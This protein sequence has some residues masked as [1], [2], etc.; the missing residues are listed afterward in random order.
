M[1]RCG[2]AHRLASSALPRAISDGEMVIAVATLT[3][4][5]VVLCSWPSLFLIA[6]R[7]HSRRWLTGLAV[8]VPCEPS[9]RIDSRTLW[10]TLHIGGWCGA[11]GPGNELRA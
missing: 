5:N 10:G 2:E 8:G 4:W 7:I 9:E 3:H 1:W 11:T 6:S